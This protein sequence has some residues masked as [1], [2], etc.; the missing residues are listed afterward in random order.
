[1]YA[2]P[3]W[4][5]TGRC[6]PPPRPRASTL[7]TRPRRPGGAERR[8]VRQEEQGKRACRA[9]VG[10]LLEVRVLVVER[11]RL[12]RS[13]ADA[14]HGLGGKAQGFG[15]QFRAGDDAG[16]ECR[17]GDGR[18]RVP[19]AA[20]TVLGRAVEE[21]LGHSQ[22]GCEVFGAQGQG[23]ALAGLY[24][25]ADHEAGCLARPLQL[26]AVVPQGCGDVVGRRA[27]NVYS[28]L[29][30]PGFVRRSARPARRAALA[31][32]QHLRGR[33]QRGCDA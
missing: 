16:F 31:V 3:R 10:A 22:V 33:T 32:G 23:R 15:R 25:V 11:V 2:G 6:C 19:R 8:R 26:F 21:L 17:S 20:G 1:M 30:L 27:L 9:A 7:Q 4:A 18:R 12:H 14:D 24:V 5:G 13:L 28:A 29:R